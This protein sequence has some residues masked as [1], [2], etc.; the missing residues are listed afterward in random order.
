MSISTL[1]AN[2]SSRGGVA[3]SNLYRVDFGSAI[4]ILSDKGIPV[5]ELRDMDLY[6]RSTTMPGKHIMTQD[7]ATWGHA[8]KQPQGFAEDDVEM[9]FEGTNDFF[10]KR[11]LDEWT[12]LVIDPNTYL[13]S[14]D[15]EYRAD[16]RISS[17]NRNNGGEEVNYTILLEGAFP[18]GTKGFPL[19]DSADNTSV[20]FSATFAYD[21]F[22]IIRS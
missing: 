19:D 15:A 7:Y 6:C 1:L 2:L 8:A 5:N 16:I 21:K 4:G 14:Y 12:D 3:V 17:L 22:T 18:L 11:I 10:V 20:K 9:V 13:I